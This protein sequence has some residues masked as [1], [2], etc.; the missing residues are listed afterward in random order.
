MDSKDLDLVKIGQNGEFGRY[1]IAPAAE[2]VGEGFA[3]STVNEQYGSDTAV[4]F[5]EDTVFDVNYK[6]TSWH[7]TARDCASSTV[8][9]SARRLTTRKSENSAFAIQYMNV[10]W[11][12]RRT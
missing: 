1:I 5:D 10:T 4:V 9:T 3:A 8:T 6:S 12:R 2:I 11:S 7:A